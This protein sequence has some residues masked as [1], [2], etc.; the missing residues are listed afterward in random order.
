MDPLDPTAGFDPSVFNNVTITGAIAFICVTVIVVTY[1]GTIKAAIAKIF[2]IDRRKKDNGNGEDNEKKRSNDTITKTEMEIILLKRDNEINEKINRIKEDLT[3]KVTA[4][5]EE[6][7]K[8][9]MDETGK[10]Y[11][12]MESNKDELLRAINRIGGASA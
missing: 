6:L 2:G 10:I 8:L 3:G 11:N 7:T 1:K 4:S 5:K 12:K 9:I